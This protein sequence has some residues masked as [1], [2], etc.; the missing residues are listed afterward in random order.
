MKVE[1][2]K[3]KGRPL[4]NIKFNLSYYELY[5]LKKIGSVKI[6]GYILKLKKEKNHGKTLRPRCIFR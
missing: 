4:K 3:L 5:M 1:V 6:G 2:I